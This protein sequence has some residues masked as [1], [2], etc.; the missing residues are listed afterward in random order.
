MTLIDAFNIGAEGLYAHAKRMDVHAKNIAN[1]DTPNYVRKI[2]VLLSKDDISFNGVM[3]N[4]KDS[5]F[6][7]GTVPYQS[8]GVAFTGVVED[9]TKG[10]LIYKPGHPDADKNGYVR[11]S[12][13]NPVV[14]MADALITSRAYEASMAIIGM[15]KS[16]EQK[17][18]EIGK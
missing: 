14:D 10:A 9:P 18:T 3:N 13:V 6:A 7:S 1:L 8:G 2:P 4:M 16:M 12:N 17:A 5:V 15:T 11:T